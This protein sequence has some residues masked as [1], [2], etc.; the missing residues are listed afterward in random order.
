MAVVYI[1][2][3]V[4]YILS[5]VVYVLG[6][7][8]CPVVTDLH[9]LCL[10]GGMG[11]AVEVLGSFHNVSKFVRISCPHERREGR[12]SFLSLEFMTE[13]PE[14]FEVQEKSRHGHPKNVDKRR[15]EGSVHSCEF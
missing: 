14:Y 7:S 6:S 1:L 11:R 9:Q 3:A 13:Y 12:K 4:V 5:A 10:Q 15:F 8:L 2:S